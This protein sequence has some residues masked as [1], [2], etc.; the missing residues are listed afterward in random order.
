MVHDG[1]NEGFFTGFDSALHG[2]DEIVG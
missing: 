2:C 1:N